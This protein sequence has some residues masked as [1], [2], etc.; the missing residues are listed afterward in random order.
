MSL[1][2]TECQNCG[3]YR[4]T[5][6]WQCEKCGLTVEYCCEDCST[7]LEVTHVCKLAGEKK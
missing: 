1:D 4:D 3:Q 7:D 5:A 6:E 2:L